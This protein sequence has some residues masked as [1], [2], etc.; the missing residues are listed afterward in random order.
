ME[1]INIGPIVKIN[2]KIKFKNKKYRKY[3]QNI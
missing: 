2:Y 1:H 3:L